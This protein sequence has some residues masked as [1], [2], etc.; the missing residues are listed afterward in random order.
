MFLGGLQLHLFQQRQVCKK[1][2][3]IVQP[4]YLIIR[5]DGRR[6]TAALLHVPRG[7]VVE[8]WVH[9]CGEVAFLCALDVSFKWPNIRNHRLEWHDKRQRSLNVKSVQLL[10]LFR[11]DVELAIIDLKKKPFPWAGLLVT[12]ALGRFTTCQT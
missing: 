3:I 2:A 5:P 12:D 7:G 11:P 4:L 1:L 8:H 9:S 10:A 6:I